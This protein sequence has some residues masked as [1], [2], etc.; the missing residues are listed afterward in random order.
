MDIFRKLIY[1][2]VPPA[3][4][5]LGNNT[6]Q[7]RIAAAFVGIVVQIDFPGKE[8]LLYLEYAPMPAVNVSNWNCSI[9]VTINL[10][11][12]YGTHEW[13]EYRN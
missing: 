5:A 13:P 7:H 11:Q 9:G 1:P 4:A 8:I 12:W 6:S 10:S 2:N 3:R